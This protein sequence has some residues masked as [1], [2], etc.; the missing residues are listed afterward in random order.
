MYT[1]TLLRKHS[2]GYVLIV[3]HAHL[4]FI[5]YPEHENHLE[6]RWLYEA[7]TETYIPLLSLFDRLINDNIDFRIALSFT[8]TL[9]EMFNDHLL[10]K[11]FRRHIEE[12]ITLSERELHRTRGDLRF[13][14]LAKMY[15]NKFKEILR[16]YADVYNQDLTSAFASLG[17]SGKIEV[18]TSA[19]T[20]AYLPALMTEPAAADAQIRLAAEYFKDTFGKKSHGFWLPECGYVPEMDISLKNAGVAYFFLESH[21]LLNSRPKSP[22]SIYAPVMTPAGSIVFARDVEST[23]QVWSSVEGY[24]G[25]FDYR[26]FYRDIGFDLDQNY[27]SPYLPSGMRTF[28]GIKYYRITDKS[29]NKEPYIPEYALRKVEQHASHFLESRERQVCSLHDRLGIQ[30]VITATFDAELFGHWWFE[31]PEW[32]DCV[33]RKGAGQKRAWKFITPSEYLAYGKE[34]TTVTPAPSSWGYKGHSET[35]IDTTNSWIY[36]HLHHG[37]KSMKEIADKKKHARGLTRRALNQAARELLLAQASDW[38]FMMKADNASA[39]AIKKFKEHMQNFFVLHKE[40]ASDQIHTAHLSV[41]E[42]KNCIFR[43]LDYRIFTD[44]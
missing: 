41:L 29:D 9:L 6:E 43:G 5:R 25:D 34:L 10:Q 16:L 31:G 8:P 22:Y 21:S 32:L 14:P 17:K 44:L 3:L 27:I 19:A 12:L 39:F 11:R 2:R 40:I 37:A 30:P 15:H 13:E 23:K 26:D 38:P 33:L 24:P 18:M 35:W 36:R 28:T 1:V 20:H 4:P 42:K 7:M